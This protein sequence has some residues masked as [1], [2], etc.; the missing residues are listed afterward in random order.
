M[1]LRTLAALVVVLAVAGC[2]SKRAP[3][4]GNAA[5]PP[6][7][8]TSDPGTATPRPVDDSVT[9]RVVAVVNND[10]I[11]LSELQES[12]AIYRYENRDRAAA[13]DEELYRMFLTKMIDSRLQLQEAER[14]KITVDDTE[15]ED[16]MRDRMK[17]LG[18]KS[19]ADLEA[20]VKAEGISM[21]AL[22]NRMRDA[23]RIN[24][25]VR[26]K[27]ALRISVTD[28]EVDQ[29]VAENQEKLETG[30]SYHARHILIAP[31]DPSDAAWE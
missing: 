9:D 10:A 8:A 24:K 14:E 2:A 1:R 11:T 6:T 16:E 19:M 17:R 29:Y 13:P 7:A 28:P 30:L 26:R 27:V 20:M 25:V 21:A 3:V 18:A 31:A 4:I 12:V 15:V 5:E 23:L 22:K